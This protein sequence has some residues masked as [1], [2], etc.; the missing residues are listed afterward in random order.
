MKIWTLMENAS[1]REDL[2][3]E[4]GLSLYIETGERKILS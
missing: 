1:C 2:A 4:H 3:A